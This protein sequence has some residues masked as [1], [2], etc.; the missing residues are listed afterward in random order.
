MRRLQD[1][2]YKATNL[3]I[4]AWMQTHNEQGS[5][6][7]DSEEEDED[8]GPTY[9]TDG[10]GECIEGIEEENTF[11]AG[12]RS[13]IVE[14]I[15][16]ENVFVDG[17]ELVEE[18]MVVVD[19]QNSVQG[20]TTARTFDFKCPK[21]SGSHI[22]YNHDLFY[23]DLKE[24][25][26]GSFVDQEG[27]FIYHRHIRFK[28]WKKIS[29]L[30]PSI[31]Y[32]LQVEYHH[33]Y[34]RVMRE[35]GG[36]LNF[37]ESDFVG[38]TC[39]DLADFDL[40]GYDLVAYD[41]TSGVSGVVLYVTQKHQ[42]RLFLDDGRFL[43]PSKD[44]LEGLKSAKFFCYLICLEKNVCVWKGNIKGTFETNK[45]DVFAAPRFKIKKSW[46]E[47]AKKQGRMGID[48]MGAAMFK[49]WNVFE[50]RTPWAV[51]GEWL[52]CQNVTH[53]MTSYL[54]PYFSLASVFQ[55]KYWKLRIGPIIIM[56]CDGDPDLIKTRGVKCFVWL[57]SKGELV[58]ISLAQRL[59]NE[60]RRRHKVMW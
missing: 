10:E 17:D 36:R 28:E 23:K 20:L 43:Y 34:D 49:S 51:F 56:A 37:I 57:W 55:I 40:L 31:E 5:I 50:V 26:S 25:R 35:F 18:M 60:G 52:I 21:F 54:M 45:G 12:N 42:V 8:C 2:A 48:D 46:T 11:M 4:Q 24:I 53:A 14:T 44:L 1:E 27:L 38:Y 33:K 15:G 30:K 9:D 59:A 3:A 22:F 29:I 58:C 47:F 32:F 19:Q 41:L 7:S 13:E 6:D 16:E 39:F